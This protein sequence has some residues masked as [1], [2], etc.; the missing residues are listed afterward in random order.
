VQ[1]HAAQGKAATFAA[2][3]GRR[4]SACSPCGNCLHAT[5]RKMPCWA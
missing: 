2:G 3:V 1:V 5:G 4:Q